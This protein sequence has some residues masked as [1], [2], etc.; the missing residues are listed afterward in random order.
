MP[1]A[2]SQGA[3]ETDLGLSAARAATVM[4]VTSGEGDPVYKVED[5]EE[6][7]DGGVD[8]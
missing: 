7:R 5:R 8:F 2:A 1:L 6:E 3:V 4:A